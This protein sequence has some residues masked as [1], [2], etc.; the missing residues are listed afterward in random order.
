MSIEFG[1]IARRKLKA[2]V[3]ILANTVK[4]TLGPKGRNV[5][6]AKTFGG[7]L[8]TKDGV[9]VA[10]EIEL[11]DQF[12]NMGAS[13]LMEVSS[14]TSDNAGDGTTTATVLGQA[15]FTRGLRLIEAGAS[16]VS[17]KR[18]MDLACTDIVDNLWGFSRRI[19]GA[20]DIQSVATIS[21][22]GDVAIGKILADCVA[23]IGNDGVITIED[24]NSLDYE[25]STVEGM[26]LGSG[27]AHPGFNQ[28]EGTCLV[29]GPL[30]LVTNL[31]VGHP[32]PLLKMLDNVIKE[33][34]SIIIIAPDFE[35]VAINTFIQN[36]DQLKSCLIKAP[37]F[38][39][40][41]QALLEDIAVLTGASLVDKS[42][43]HTFD[44]IFREGDLSVLGSVDTASVTQR[45]F[46]LSGGGGT[47][48]ALET[49]ISAL[50]HLA[51][52]SG[53][54]YDKEKIRERLG[55]LQGG[56]CVIK[57]GA[58]TEIELKE[59][60]S[61]LEDALFATRAAISEGIVPGGGIALLRAAQIC[62]PPVNAED[63]DIELG[64]QLVLDSCS[65]PLK[66]ILDNAGVS[67]SLLIAQILDSG[68]M[69]FGVDLSG[70]DYRL[71]N[72]YDLGVIDTVKV[73]RNAIS[74]AV[75][76]VGTMLTTECM[77]GLTPKTKP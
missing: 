75:S 17:L 47:E 11:D 59:R 21:A 3:D 25:V 15:I 52:T 44:S 57:V 14:T 33:G 18:G 35:G 16:P 27:W 58:F 48:E 49:R 63:P 60:K 5:A 6:I 13:L 69:S 71:G 73:C 74:N 54:E 41:Q 38:G 42:Q 50:Q 53:S 64:Y 2:G 67:S 12:E 55:K 45:T 43:G 22:N 66:C 51:E 26:Q 62:E 7:V 9:T 23:K 46:T 77:L 68:D 34:R 19:K 56:V 40:N 4:I 24:G 39:M 1:T 28:G 29:E 31:T 10:R 70:E 20:S 61:R 76:A 8:V 72:M 37:G 65:A 36:L 32:Q 30:V